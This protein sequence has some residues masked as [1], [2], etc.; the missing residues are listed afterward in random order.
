MT[1]KTLWLLSGTNYHIQDLVIGS[2]WSG[3]WSPCLEARLAQ[4]H[5]QPGQ[6]LEDLQ[7]T[8]D[9]GSAFDIFPGPQSQ[10]IVSYLGFPSF[11][12]VFPII[13]PWNSHDLKW[14]YQLKR[15]KPSNNKWSQP[16]PFRTACRP[17]VLAPATERGRC[18]LADELRHGCHGCWPWLLGT[19]TSTSGDSKGVESGWALLRY[20]VSRTVM[21]HGRYRL[22]LAVYIWL[23]IQLIVS[24]RIHLKAD[25]LLLSF[26]VQN[27]NRFPAIFEADRLAIRILTIT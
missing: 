18:L 12:H 27:C 26:F 17:A 24:E 21:H 5:P 19:S 10:R 1:F 2:L 20:V 4:F 15:L 25:W 23:P 9:D 13:S 6:L 16:Q 14:F 3:T 22:G 8:F 11:S 7:V